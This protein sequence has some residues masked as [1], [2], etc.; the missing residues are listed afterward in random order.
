MKPSQPPATEAISAKPFFLFALLFQLLIIW[1]LPIGG[2]EA[3]FV[4]WGQQFSGGYYDH[5][6]LTGWLS[7]LL[8]LISTSGYAHRF[9]SVLLGLG[10]V[11]LLYRF[12][13]DRHATATA[14]DITLVYLLLPINILLFSVYVNDT[15]L[16]ASLLVFLLAF[17]RAWQLHDT[18][19]GRS[20]VFAII[21]GIAF[22]LAMMTKY[23]ASIY[24]FTLSLYL[25][26]N[27]RR[28]A[29]FLMRHYLLTGTIAAAIFS[30]NLLWNYANCGINLAFNFVLRDSETSST[31]LFELIGSLLLLLGPMVLFVHYRQL[32]NSGAIRRVLTD[33]A[34]F[35]TGLFVITAI[36]LTIIATLRGSFS[37]HWGAPIVPIAILALAEH[38]E[39]LKL[40]QLIRWNRVYS[41]LLLLPLIIF[42]SLLNYAPIWT[43]GWMSEKS[44]FRS[45]QLV[46]IHNHSL[47]QDIEQRYADK[48]L[49]TDSYGVTS[50]LENNSKLPAVLLFNTTSKF[51]RNHDIFKDY[52]SFDGKDFLIISTSYKAEDMTPWKDYFSGAEEVELAGDNGRY[53]AL[54]GIGFDYQRYRQQQIQRTLDKLYRKIPPLYGACYMDRYR[55]W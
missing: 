11:Y 55:P 45:R 52:A 43:S 48:I 1:S 10:S 51:G 50:M 38:A 28:F 54:A 34:G 46:D 33:P 15:L 8:G 27:W 18:Q 14:R 16:Y 21:A 5:P 44:A 30:I 19:P 3:Y 40:R 12:V 24:F 7:G 41:L 32:A 47:I 35:F 49:A 31:G 25:L 9:F 6:P 2:D 37:L 36:L 29:G 23:T 17:H 26:I 53:P 13:A 4:A 39:A 20:Y 42:F 22:G